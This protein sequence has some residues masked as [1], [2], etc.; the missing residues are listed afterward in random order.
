VRL[1][2]LSEF[3]AH[4]QNRRLQ[5]L[6]ELSQIRGADLT[7]SERLIFSTIEDSETDVRFSTAEQKLVRDFL[8]KR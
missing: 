1:E 6:F 4:E 5:G 3:E 2:P 8:A 7:D